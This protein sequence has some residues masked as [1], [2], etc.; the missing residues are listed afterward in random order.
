MREMMKTDKEKALLEVYKAT[1]EFSDYHAGDR[2]FNFSYGESFNPVLAAIKKLEE[3]SR[4]E[5]IPR[6]RSC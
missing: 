2:D 5:S 4:R 3:R 6:L 1:K